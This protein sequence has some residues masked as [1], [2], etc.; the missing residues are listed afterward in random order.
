MPLSVDQ[1]A[2]LRIHVGINLQ[3]TLMLMTIT[4]NPD[5]ALYPVNESVLT[6]EHTLVYGRPSPSATP[7]K[8]PEPHEPESQPAVK[9]SISKMPGGYS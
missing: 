8:L 9:C 4:T 3:D 5:P 2:T 7:D 6:L 1:R